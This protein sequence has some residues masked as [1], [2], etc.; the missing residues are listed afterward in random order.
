MTDNFWKDKYPVGVA[1]EINPDEYQN[2]QA[3]LR[4]SCERFAD[5]P[6]FSNLGKTLTYG[7]LY[8]LSGDFAAYLQQNT[9]LQPGDRI[10]VQLPNLIQYPIVVFGAM[11]AGLIV[12]NTNPLYTAREMEHQFNDAGAK[13]LVCLAN[14]AHLAE[15]VLPKTGIKH[16]VITEVADMLPPLKRMLI[17]AVVKHVKKMV[18]AYSLPK[19]VKLN[20]ALALGRGKA[21]RE[22]S[23]KS[24]DVAVLQYTGGTTGVAKG[25]MLTHRNIVANMLQCKA[26]MGANLNDGSEV[27]IAPLPLYHIYA[28]TFHCMA[29]MLSGNHN[30]LISNPRDLPAMIK[31]LGKYRFS[32]FVGLNTLFVALCNSEDF[33]KLDFSAL[34]V[35]LS[36]GMALQLATAER[37]K[38]VTGC[39]ICEG[40]GLTETSPV[41]SVNPIEHIQ[42]G[43]IGI[44]VPSTQFKVINDDGQELA[45]GE[46]G[47]LCIKGPQVMKGYWQRPEATDEVI[48]ADG[49]FKTGDIGVIQEDGYIR[50]VDRKKDMILVSGFNVYPNE[51]EDV[52]ASLP[53]VL[54]CAAIGVPDEKSGEAIKLFVVVKPGESL[55]KEQVMQHMHD[56]LT[57][58]KRPRY[59]E[60]RESLPTTN[61]GKILRRELRDEELRKLGH[62]K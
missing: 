58:Y 3:V 33:R 38:Q 62:K 48:D 11:R 50:I 28:F 34:K 39:P 9:D 57:G 42:L 32:G 17:N 2:I 14:M 16:V 59:V 53:G 5:K 52:L 25:A 19:A 12:V 35:T 31:D 61:V 23:P 22:A 29:M 56:N 26:L 7:E 37:W 41:A 24:E 15:E 18:P 6:A 13:A 51:L 20:D 47:E 44:P 27:L 8:K 21:V 49:W 30:I 54:Q 55:T 1:S 36:G 10:A 43:S 60:F 40:Y 46:I 45:Q 4:Q